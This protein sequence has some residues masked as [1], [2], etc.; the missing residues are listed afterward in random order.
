MTRRVRFFRTGLG[1]LLSWLCLLGAATPL[2]GCDA[3]VDTSGRKSC[4]THAE[5]T[6]R[7]GEPSTCVESSCV[8]LLSEECT[9]VLPDGL[10]EEDN[11]LLFGFMG[12]LRGDDASYGTP[13]KEGAQVAFEEI[14]RLTNGLPGVQG[15]G[16]RHAGM[17][18]CDHGADPA[19]N[20][21]VAR[22]LIEDARVPAI[23]GPSFSGVT[24][25]VFENVAHPAG[26][27]VLSAT[28]TSPA[29]T[30][31]PDDGLL[32]R[33]APSDVVQ[34]ELLK[35]LVPEVVS[36]LRA[37]GTIS[38]DREPRIALLYKDD[39][40]GGGLQRAAT[41]KGDSPNAAPAIVSDHQDKYPDPGGGKSIDWAPFIE[42]VLDY[43][44][45]IIL[46]LGTGEFV[47]NI[48]PGIEAGWSPK[49]PRPWYVLPEG[50]RVDQ[51]KDAAARN[52]SWHLEQRVLGTAPGARQAKLY[53][54]FENAFRSTFNQR[55]PGN[56]AEFA[57]DAAYLLAYGVAI[58][59]Q[60]FPNGRELATALKQ[61]TCGDTL[62]PAGS[63]EFSA[64]F[65]TAGRESCINF[66]G[67]SG[68]LDFNNDTGE[69][70]SDI[71]TWCLRKDGNGF[72]FDPLLA[73]YYSAVQGEFVRQSPPL[74]LTDPNWCNP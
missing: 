32:W 2:L 22:H 36:A 31:V 71:A 14:E 56:M 4:S 34:A 15:Q 55:K 49:A 38:A 21:R 50:N 54:S 41:S 6:Q 46:G 59:G 9:E 20:E 37:A 51:L 3:I 35:F 69:A 48:M 70:V 39:A 25:R 27:L 63:L 47:T 61:T 44:P 42:S 68:A 73:S 66:D 13:T 26:A 60:A 58:S 52:P 62:F 5:C 11:V 45:D 23:I 17:L 43:E 18:V 65:L 8:K 57:Y 29:I 64:Y 19:A 67:A 33:T 74:D 72:S 30:T 1:G 53:P 7:F 28:A 24:I 16:K 10:L 12:A 40:A